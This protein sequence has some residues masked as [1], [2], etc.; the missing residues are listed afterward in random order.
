MAA[1]IPSSD[2]HL[3][4]DTTGHTSDHNNIVDILKLISGAALGGTVT[5]KQTM[6]TVT[7]S[8][9]TQGQLLLGTAAG[10]SVWT[11]PPFVIVTPSGDTSGVTDTNNLTTAFGLYGSTS[12]VQLVPGNYYVT[13][14]SVD[15]SQSRL[16]TGPNTIINGVSAGPTISWHGQKTAAPWG[17]MPAFFSG[18]M[19][20]FMMNGSAAPAGAIGMDIGDGVHFELQHV[21]VLSYNKAGSIGINLNNSFA[22]FWTERSHFQAWI[23]DCTQCVH[24]TVSGTAQWSF[25][26]NVFDFVCQCRT[27]DDGA[28]VNQS[29]VLID[30]GAYISKG[31]FRLRGNWSTSASAM[32]TTALTISGSSGG[33][34]S[35]IDQ[36]M[37]NILC[38]TDNGRAHNPIPIAFGTGNYMRNCNGLLCFDDGWAAST[39]ASSWAGPTLK[40]GGVIDGD[41]TLSS[42][43]SAPLG[44]L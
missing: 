24:I 36:S 8:T 42:N 1:V 38:E 29:G 34:T 2:T 41:T 11:Q 39:S 32:S 33:F 9:P 15:N 30:N 35:H 31:E 26:F 44:W 7:G 17:L 37:V 43:N 16:G 25:E 3:T 5:T 10:G 6:Q 28:A 18:S 22:S 12:T 23:E 19:R 27:T 4:T 20:D 13:S 21:A 40:F 14:L